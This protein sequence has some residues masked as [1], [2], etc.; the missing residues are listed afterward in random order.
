[1]FIFNF[2]NNVKF[3][4]GKFKLTNDYEDCHSAIEFYL[5]NEHGDLGDT[6]DPSSF[7]KVAPQVEPLCSRDSYRNPE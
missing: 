2:K 7:L 6:V 4:N 5:T 1:M 3:I